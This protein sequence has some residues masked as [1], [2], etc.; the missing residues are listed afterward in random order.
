MTDTTT[1]IRLSGWAQYPAVDTHLVMPA[2]VRT[3]AVS[4]ARAPGPCI[5]RGMGRS[6]GDAS[7]AAHTFDMTRLDYLL[8]FDRE[9]GVL[10]ASAGITLAAIL[11][12]IVPHGWFLPALPGTGQVSLGGAI[13]ADVHGKNHHHSGSFSSHL[14]SIEVMTAAGSIVS[15][16]R[17][18]D[19]DL[20][21]ATAGGMGLT[22]II[23]SAR[24]RLLPISSSFIEHRILPTSGLAATLDL[25]AQH[26]DVT[27]VVAW[28]DINRRGADNGRGL[29]L[30]GEHASDGAL[31]APAERVLSVPCSLP[32]GC[33]NRPLLQA[34]NALYFHHGARR[35]GHHRVHYSA[36]F[37]PLDRLAHWYRL[38]GRRGF[39]QHQCVLPP[40]SAPQ[41]LA[42]LLACIG[43][44]GSAAPLAV[45]KRFGRGN[46]QLLSFPHAGLTLAVDLPLNA[47]TLALCARLDDI[48]VSHGGRLYLAKD[49]CMSR[50]T[51]RRGYPAWERFQEIRERYGA[52]G[53]F[54]SLQSARL[55]L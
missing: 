55:G 52:L 7:L 3:L 39:V 6:Y 16:T 51:F 15:C 27:Y 13:A 35:H 19:A 33:L 48:V 44:S 36:Y 12:L 2:T 49:A 38:Y 32:S 25:L 17:D 50:A 4:L 47:D 14:D 10:H 23:V 42:E 37:F 24:L 5:A 11:A 28:I 9:R 34:V 18:T 43:R 20:F 31:S 53:R 29:V 30:L 45:L 21:H 54:A 41:A 8:D 22:G 1:T 40:A 46:P 26:D